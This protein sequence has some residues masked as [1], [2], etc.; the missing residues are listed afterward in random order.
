MNTMRVNAEPEEGLSMPSLPPLPLDA[1]ESTQNTLQLFMQIIGKIRLKL[2][3]RI[4]HWWHVTLYVSCHG[5]TTRP[6]PFEDKLFEIHLDLINHQLVV[7]CSEGPAR[8]FSLQDTSVAEFYEKLFSILDD[9]GIQVEIKAEPYDLAFSTIPFA[10]DE[11]HASYDPEYI[12]RYWQILKFVSTT[13]EEFRGRF[14]G[15]S[16][17]VHLFWHHADLALTRFS[18]KQAPPLQGGTNA[19]REAYSH[20]V[21]SSG[22]WV[23]DDKTREP[24][25]YTYIYPEPD[26]L[27][28]T[29][30]QP[31][32]AQWR[33]DYG[34]TMAFM[35]Y[36]AIREADNPRAELL[37]YLQSAYDACVQRA[38][39][40]IE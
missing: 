17:P 34:Y 5:L 39:W 28:G 14:I 15:K 27:S 31:A 40:T 19:D 23:G 38:G 8:S 4:N 35:P 21:I 16:T 22:F 20:E 1:W 6:I 32:A 30:L 24:A 9:F 18:G 36:A 12:S 7:S 2:H 33:N 37:T 29:T 10:I 13:F 3:P 26:G 25:F 11:Q